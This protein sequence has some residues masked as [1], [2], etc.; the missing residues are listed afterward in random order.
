MKLGANTYRFPKTGYTSTFSICTKMEHQLKKF[1]RDLKNYKVCK[2]YGCSSATP[3]L[4]FH[5]KKKHPRLVEGNH[6]L[7][8][9]STV[10]ERC[11]SSTL[12]GSREPQP[13]RNPQSTTL[14]WWSLAS[15][16]RQL[17]PCSEYSTAS[18][19]SGIVI[20]VQ[21]VGH[22]EGAAAKSSTNALLFCELWSS[23]SNSVDSPEIRH[24]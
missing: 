19:Y 13:Q 11:Y 3:N 22:V 1:H 6:L 23:T 12:R 2:V 17:L 15:V 9:T 16:S 14:S 18:M 20:V 7:S 5:M 21:W 24:I 4:P 8:T 10:A